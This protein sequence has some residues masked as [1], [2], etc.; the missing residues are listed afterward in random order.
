MHPPTHMVPGHSATLEH[1]GSDKYAITL[2]S[3]YM[4]SGTP[5]EFK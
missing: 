3:I 5:L 2:Y 4:L 1:V